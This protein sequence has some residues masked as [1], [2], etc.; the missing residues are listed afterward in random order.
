[1]RRSAGAETA[2]ILT[3]LVI[4]GART[5]AFVRSR[6][7]AE[8]TAL[9]ARRALA[10]VDESLAE[11]V[12]AYRAGFLPEDR[13]ALEK[14]LLDGELLGVASTNA[15]ELGV[16]IAGL[17]AVVVAGFPGTLASFWQQAGRAGRTGDG[18]LVVFVARDDPLDTYLVHHPAAVL[19]RPIEATVLDPANPYVLAPQL[20]CAAAELPLS[21]DCLPEFGGEAAEAVLATL[22]ADGVLRRRPRGWYWTRRERPHA[23]VD[24]RGIGGEQIA[25]V[26][27]DS[28]RMLGTVDPAAACATVHEGAVYLHQGQSYVV[29][30][31]DLASSLALVHSENPEW[32]TSP[33]EVVDIS[34]LR[35]T[36]QDRF[37]TDDGEVTV[38]ARRR[39]GDLAD[40]GLP[41][42][43][44][45]G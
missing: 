36:R 31:L 21:T 3:D 32:T 22:V 38:C 30:E 23:E 42:A 7:G 40:R 19:D 24:I 13:R 14:G 17:D 44:A 25:V 5:L 35:T 18:A 29:D 11:R 1:M 9:A 16:D 39:R 6:R 15:L 8:L 41:A 45:V 26:E 37:K 27:A 20:V 4:E 43:V 28:G 12:A 33:R 34:V 10:E 2:R